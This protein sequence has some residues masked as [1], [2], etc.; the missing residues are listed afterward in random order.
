MTLGKITGASKSCAEQ[1]EGSRLDNRNN[2]SVP[3]PETNKQVQSFLGL[4]GYYQCFLPSYA[5]MVA[6]LT[7]VNRKCEPEIVSWSEDCSK[8]FSELKE[9]L[10][11]PVLRNVNFSEWEQL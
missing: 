6:P 9:M 11:Y 4:M 1:A 5:S 3:Q 2:S 10:S 7:N 8:V